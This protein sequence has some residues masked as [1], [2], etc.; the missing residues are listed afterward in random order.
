LYYDNDTYWI[1]AETYEK[2]TACIV[3][4]DSPTALRILAVWKRSAPLLDSVKRDT[5]ESDLADPEFYTF[6]G[7]SREDLQLS[8][9]PDDNFWTIATMVS[10]MLK[11]CHRK[12]SAGRRSMERSLE[13]LEVTYARR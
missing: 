10:G 6:R 1:H 2:E 11:Y 7:Y 12:S 8:M 9:P 5:E 3:N 13:A 4:L